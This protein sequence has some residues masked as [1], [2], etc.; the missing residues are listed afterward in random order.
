MHFRLQERNTADMHCSWRRP[1][2]G[3]SKDGRQQASP[4]PGNAWGNKT[5]HSNKPAGSGQNAS[6]PAPKEEHVPVREFNAVEVRDYLKKSEYSQRH[7]C[8][9]CTRPLGVS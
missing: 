2:Q 1:G 8:R 5:A 7:D 9:R 6:V 4:S 3:N